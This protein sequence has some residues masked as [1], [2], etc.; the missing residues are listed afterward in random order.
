MAWPVWK[1]CVMINPLL[2]PSTLPFAL[3]PFTDIAPSHYAE[4]AE[5]GFTEHLAEVRAITENPD[6][7]TFENTAVAMERS[8]QLLQRTAA[9]R[10]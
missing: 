3:P 7:A 4:A 9:V 8:G 1:I 5:A 2:A 10:V 6:P